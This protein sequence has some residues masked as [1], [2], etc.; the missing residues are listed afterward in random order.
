MDFPGGTS[1]KELVCQCRRHQRHGFFPR[2]WKIP[3]RKAWQPTLVFLPVCIITYGHMYVDVYVHIYIY[4]DTYLSS[5]SYVRLCATLW[6]VAHQA[7]LS[8]GFSRQEYWS[9]P[10][11]PPQRDLPNSGIKPASAAQEADSLQLSHWGSP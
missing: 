9:A 4:T 8:M 3:W 6:T 2:V 5:F 7:P 10:P 11:W 1:D